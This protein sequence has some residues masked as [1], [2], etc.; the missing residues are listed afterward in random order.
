MLT[1]VGKKKI[2]Q[3]NIDNR[4]R[5]G[6]ESNDSFL[7]ENPSDF[8]PEDESEYSL[9]NSENGSCSVSGESAICDQFVPPEVPTPRF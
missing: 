1:R 4:Q 5:I 2:D 3:S 8:E 7:D 6:I 9:S